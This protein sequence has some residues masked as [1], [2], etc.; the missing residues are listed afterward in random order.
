MRIS[1][2]L[3][4]FWCTWACMMACA[5]DD[6]LDD[7]RKVQELMRHDDPRATFWSVGFSSDGK[8]VAA[9]YTKLPESYSLRSQGIRH[10]GVH[11]FRLGTDPTQSHNIKIEDHERCHVFSRGVTD[12]SNADPTSIAFVKTSSRDANRDPAR[13]PLTRRYSVMTA[14]LDGSETEMSVIET[15]ASNYQ[16]QYAFSADAKL[17][18]TAGAM[19]N[20]EEFADSRGEVRLWNLESGKQLLQHGWGHGKY[21]A[22][23]FSPDSKLIAAGGGYVV[24]NVTVYE[25]GRRFVGGGNKFRGRLRIWDARTG[26]ELLTNDFEDHSIESLAFSPDGK[27]LVSG[28]FDNA[29]HVWKLAPWETEHTIHIPDDPHD[30][31]VQDNLRAGKPERSID[32]SQPSADPN[33]SF[34]SA[35]LSSVSFSPDGRFLVIGTGSWNRGGK[36]GEVRL[37]DTENWKLQMTLLKKHPLLVTSVQFSPDGT[38]LAA[39]TGDGTLVVWDTPEL[40]IDK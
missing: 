5:A 12:Q 11:V 29:V 39:V 8:T 6:S 19:F 28:G 27:V 14:T 10:A 20:V 16:N 1:T 4:V 35:R 18:A 22:V 2:T 31:F 13:P 36:W 34:A 23:A 9:G 3:A 24:P 30:E 26:D 32:I 15:P 7:V 40:K 38:K 37:Y 21:Q 25:D 33:E 17:L